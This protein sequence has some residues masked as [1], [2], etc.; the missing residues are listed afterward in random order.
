MKKEIFQGIDIEQICEEFGIKMVR[1]MKDVK[2]TSNVAYFNFRCNYVNKAIHN[3][4][5]K[6]PEN[7]VI[8]GTSVWEGLELQCKKHF[9]NK[10]VLKL[11]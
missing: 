1:D 10:G 9:K 5:K 2:T 6:P 11:S 3:K 8:E 4:A 7:S